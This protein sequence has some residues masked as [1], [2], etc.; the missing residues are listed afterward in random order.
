MTYPDNQ[1]AIIQSREPPRDSGLPF[2]VTHDRPLPQLSEPFEV[3]VRVLTVALNPADYLFQKHDYIEGNGVG[4]EFC[5]IV[6]EA[7]SQSIHAVGTRVTGSGNLPYCQV[8]R[9]TGAFA[10]YMVANSRFILGVPDSMGSVQAAA[11]SASWWAPVLAMSDPDALNL[12]ALPSKPS[13]QPNIV[14]VYGGGTSSGVMAIQVLKLSGYAPLVVCSDK[15]ASR[16]IRLGAVGTVSYTSPTCSEN[17]KKLAG[18]RSIK[19]ALD[20]ITSAESFA[21]CMDCL[22]RVGSRYACLEP[23]PDCWITRRAVKYKVVMCY[24]VQG[25]DIEMRDPAWSRKYSP[26]LSEILARWTREMQNLLD[27]EK[28]VT[29]PTWE[30]PGRFEGIITALELMKDGE[31][32]KYRVVVTISP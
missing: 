32:D 25:Y 5:G 3:L 2:I 4:Y 17:I 11:L 6:Q 22:D 14:L 26:L 7:G 19:Y 8:N 27:C 29:K 9:V 18:G 31:L 12:P 24:G 30:I 20:C 28:I 13:E 16:A 1:T 21:T 23:F 10:E 15:S